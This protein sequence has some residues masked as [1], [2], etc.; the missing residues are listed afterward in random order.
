MEGNPKN[1]NAWWAIRDRL[2][3]RLLPEHPTKKQK[4]R[5]LWAILW[6][7]LYVVAI[8][9]MALFLLIKFG[10]AH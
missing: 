1:P 8:A 6:A 9:S 5:M 10:L 7:I 2:W 4:R 3:P